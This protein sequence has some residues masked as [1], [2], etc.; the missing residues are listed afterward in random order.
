MAKTAHHLRDTLGNVYRLTV[1]PVD[2]GA[3]FQI[4]PNLWDEAWGNPSYA[5]PTEQNPTYL[6]LKDGNGTT[7]YMYGITEDKDGNYAFSNVSPVTAFGIWNEPTYETRTV[8]QGTVIHYIELIDEDGT[9]WYIYPD[10]NGETIISP[11][12]PA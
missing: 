5:I 11:T 10:A 8:Q 7:W 4:D 9:S 2:A 12:E 6:T 3:E 1:I